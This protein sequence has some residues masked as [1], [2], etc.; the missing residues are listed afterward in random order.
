MVLRFDRISHFKIKRT[1]QTF[2][3]GVSFILT[4][5]PFADIV[6]FDHI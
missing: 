1:A 4:A 6:E 2:R 5:L 3:N